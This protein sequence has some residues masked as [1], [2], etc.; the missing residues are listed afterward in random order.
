MVLLRDIECLL[1]QH[2]LKT[3]RGN[4]RGMRDGAQMHNKKWASKSQS[5]HWYFTDITLNRRYICNSE[6]AEAF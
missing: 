5:L 3:K 2:C 6:E 4:R 1:V